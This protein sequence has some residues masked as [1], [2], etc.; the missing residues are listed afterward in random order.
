M[1]RRYHHEVADQAKP[2]AANDLAG[3]PA[4]DH[5]DGRM[6][7]M[8]SFDMFRGIL[9]AGPSPYIAPSAWFNPTG[10]GACCLTVSNAAFETLRLA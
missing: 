8:L 10:R 6:T 9:P 1:K 2:G 7:R 4:G 3:Q 5:A